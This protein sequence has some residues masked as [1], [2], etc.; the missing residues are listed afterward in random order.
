M[1]EYSD[2]SDNDRKQQAKNNIFDLIQKMFKGQS[3]NAY[4][5]DFFSRILSQTNRV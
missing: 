3:Y 5:E 1:L 2:K 4:K